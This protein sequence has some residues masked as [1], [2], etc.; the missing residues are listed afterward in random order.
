MA[1][2]RDRRSSSYIPVTFEWSLVLDEHFKGCSVTAVLA[3]HIH[4]H[5]PMLIPGWYSIFE[6]SLST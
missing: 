6:F 1:V 4:V 5:I 3:C 2:L